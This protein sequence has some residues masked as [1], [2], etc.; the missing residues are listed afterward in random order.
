[1]GTF[2]YGSPEQFCALGDRALLHLQIVMIS[3]LRRGER[4]MF[5][6]D[7]DD[8][9]RPTEFW[10]SPEIPLRFL[11]AENASGNVNFAWLNMLVGTVGG[12]GALH[13][14]PEPA[15]SRP[16]LVARS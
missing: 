4:F 12:S 9:S 7:P 11:Y 16:E 6:Y 13:L 2:V 3:K 14:L 5:R 1:M 10:M 8:T 15:S